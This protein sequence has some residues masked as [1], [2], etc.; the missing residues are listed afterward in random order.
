MNKLIQIFIS[1]ILI[2]QFFSAQA[3]WSPSIAV[4]DNLQIT[5]TLFTVIISSYL[6]EERERVLD[7]DSK[8]YSF[9]KQNA[10]LA[11][12]KLLASFLSEWQ[13]LIDQNKY[14]T[15]EQIF[16]VIYSQKPFYRKYAD[17]LKSLYDFRFQVFNLGGYRNQALNEI[18]NS[19][20]LQ[21]LPRIDKI[22]QIVNSTLIANSR[23]YGSAQI[24]LLAFEQSSHVELSNKAK[25]SLNN[26]DRS[27]YLS[28]AQFIFGL[29][30]IV[31]KAS[32]HDMIDYRGMAELLQNSK[33]TLHIAKNIGKLKLQQMKNLVNPYISRDKALLNALI[34]SAAAHGA[35]FQLLSTNENKKTSEEDVKRQ[36]V[37]DPLYPFALMWQTLFE[38]R[39]F[40]F[41][42]AS[43]LSLS[44]T[45]SVKWNQHQL[46]EYLKKQ[47]SDGRKNL[48]ENSFQTVM[49]SEKLL[50]ID[51][52][53]DDLIFDLGMQQ[54]YEIRNEIYQS[55]GKEI[56]TNQDI[57]VVRKKIIELGL[58]KYQRDFP[59][60]TSV[61]VG[62]GG[63]C[64]SE[65]M[66]FMLMLS[67]F[68]MTPY[69]SPMVSFYQDH[70]EPVIYD[71]RNKT[72]IELMSGSLKKQLNSILYYP[73]VLNAIILRQFSKE[74]ISLDRF[75]VQE[76]EGQTLLKQLNAM[77]YS[78]YE[79]YNNNHK[80]WIQKWKNQRAPGPLE[81]ILSFEGRAQRN[82]GEVP[83][84]MNTSYS[85]MTEVSTD[86]PEMMDSSIDDQQQQQK[87]D[88]QSQDEKGKN[89]NG[90]K[91][92]GIHMLPKKPVVI[93]SQIL[94]VKKISQ[95]KNCF[96]YE[97]DDVRFIPVLQKMLYLNTSNL[98]N[99][100]SF[101]HWQALNLKVEEMNIE[102]I[103]ENQ[104]VIDLIENKLSKFQLKELSDLELN[105]IFKEL[106]ISRNGSLS[107]AGESS[108]LQMIR[109]DHPQIQRYQRYLQIVNRW[110]DYWLRHPIE[111]V[112]FL[113]SENAFVI[114]ED[115][116]S[117]KVGDIDKVNAR[118]LIDKLNK[119]NVQI[120][121]AGLVMPKG[122][123]LPVSNYFGKTY[124]LAN[125]VCQKNKLKIET[126]SGQFI[127]I[128]Q[129][130]LFELMALFQSGIQLWD[131]DSIL[132]LVWKMNMKNK[133]PAL[134]NNEKI[135]ANAILLG[136]FSYFDL[137]LNLKRIQTDRKL[138]E[139]ELSLLNEL[140]RFSEQSDSNDELNIYDIY[141]LKNNEA[142]KVS[143]SKKQ[144]LERDSKLTKCKMQKGGIRCSV[145]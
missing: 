74:K 16:S 43:E 1:L 79:A 114:F 70:I 45:E 73:Q 47:L 85:S 12:E 80:T 138:S 30:G 46:A 87:S 28:M 8:F 78:Q 37:V 105:I 53:N 60:L 76:N 144:V 103:F 61:S 72:Y 20:K 94:G 35:L 58:S 123:E 68:H 41:T 135:F 145:N 104:I 82:L 90:S 134:S 115:F 13:K 18:L 67:E 142:S 69:Y 108:M 96:Y 113:P 139:T 137:I 57:E 24:I 63:N 25:A 7:Q 64:V 54:F 23:D 34:A 66:Y 17:Y 110:L 56:R 120:C 65:T 143:N 62:F 98:L 32:N 77:P 131:L 140:M 51:G 126:S 97:I 81:F 84:S 112:N 86:N 125:H 129:E 133:K 29:V 95:I 52:R 42:N 11:D 26:I 9:A 59:N 106:N 99:E 92:C 27:I 88:G 5:H 119:S 38:K 4:K 10:Y 71:L 33:R 22:F 100:A 124:V 3:E 39:S 31:K 83:K 141:K 40:I 75:S 136:K 118:E 117:S 132:S 109:P 48:K 128:S 21:Y 55:I 93:Y 116:V 44:V 122:I 107:I 36:A 50:N 19:E 130:N 89:G 102:Y 14:S 127:Q 15:T 111:L 101:D 2:F 121:E 91:K 49:F 6:D